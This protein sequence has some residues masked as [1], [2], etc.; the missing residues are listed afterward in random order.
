MQT[1]V[2]WLQLVATHFQVLGRP[3]MGQV[4]SEK[5][6]F[7]AFIERGNAVVLKRTYSEQD[8]LES[9]PNSVTN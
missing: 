7:Q 6:I 3:N 1:G 9:N 5:R 8:C 4:A 2:S